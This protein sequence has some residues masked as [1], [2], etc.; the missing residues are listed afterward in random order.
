MKA[1]R[2]FLVMTVLTGVIYPLLIWGIATV[3]FPWKSHGS[4]IKDASGKVIGSELIA[5]SFQK[6]EFFWPRPSAVSYNPES[7][8][9]SNLGLTSADL[10]KQFQD[11]QKAG[12]VGDML[13]TSGSGLDPHVSPEAVEA[14][15]PR[16]AKARGL[17]EKVVA[18]LVQSYKEQR[19][20]HFMGEER[21]NVLK[22]NLA[23]EGL[24]K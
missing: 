4:L 6:P 24:K 5:Q 22:L 23:L 18:Q 12:A 15:I 19:Q 3:A 9:G 20:L 2:I 17:D 7:S 11:R 8:G 10:Y 1:L 16:V 14:Q 21:V 13:W